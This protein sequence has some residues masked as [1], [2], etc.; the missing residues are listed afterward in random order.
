MCDFVC[1]FGAVSCRPVGSLLLCV[2]LLVVGCYVGSVPGGWWFLVLAIPRSVG[3]DRIVVY[4][5]AASGGSRSV[6]CMEVLI[7]CRWSV[8]W[9]GSGLSACMVKRW[10]V[11]CGV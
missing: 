2:S 3:E 7:V 10:L 4:G 1:D 5:G 9:Q 8:V 6:C 11:L